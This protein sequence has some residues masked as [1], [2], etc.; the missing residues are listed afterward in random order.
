M[1]GWLVGCFLVETLGE[2]ILCDGLWM[3]S[4]AWMPCSFADRRLDLADAS[5]GTRQS[6]HFNA[7]HHFLTFHARCIQTLK[8]YAPTSLLQLTFQ[9]SPVGPL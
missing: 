7:F 3:S 8:V 4:G 5:V 2:V 9:F 6:T 1:V